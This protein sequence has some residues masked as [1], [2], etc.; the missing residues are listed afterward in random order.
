M[1]SPAGVVDGLLVDRY[2]LITRIGAGGMGEVWR[3]ED[4][5]L[6]RVVAVKTLRAGQGDDGE[7][8]VRFRAEA[9]AAA[10]LSHPGIAAIHDFGELSDSAW[11]VMELVEGDPLSRVLQRAGRLSVEQTL[12]LV[13]QVAAALS[14]AHAAGVVHRDIKPGNLLVRADDVVK[15]TDFGIATTADAVPLTQTGQVIGTP[16]YLSPEQAAG[17]PAS[18]QS[19]LYALGVVAY[20]CVSGLRPFAAENPVAELLAHLQATP[21]DLPADVPPPV[22]SLVLRLLSK[23][24][25]DR[26]ADAETLRAEVGEA[27]R[28]L[29]GTGPGPSVSAAPGVRPVHRRASSAGPTSRQTQRWAVRGAALLL[30]LLAVGLGLLDGSEDGTTRV[31][32]IAVGTPETT[33]SGALRQAELRPVVERQADED[34][35]PGQVLDVLPAGGTEL[36]LGEEVVLVVS[37]GRA[38]ARVENAPSPSPA[39]QVPTQDAAVAPASPNAPPAP[40]V[41]VRTQDGAVPPRSTRTPPAPATRVPEEP[42]NSRGAD[43]GSRGNS[44]NEGRSGNDGRNGNNGDG[45]TPGGRGSKGGGP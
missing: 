4:L 7:H 23:Q 30:A 20:E 14:A 36:A 43:G 28:A 1:S 10:R 32:V 12:D 22:R 33:A 17:G 9:R 19:D 31:P 41:E 2:R 44:G 16:G 29:V 5:L 27:R 39:A 18:P 45:S 25:A 6:R 15:V 40:A 37:T 8:R 21:P 35:P 42:G 38:H 26:P 3:A 34:L 13:A 11:I 24:P